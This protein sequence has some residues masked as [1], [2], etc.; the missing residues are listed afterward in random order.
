MRAVAESQRRSRR[1]AGGGAPSPRPVDILIIDDD[2]ALADDLAAALEGAGHRTA[3]ATDLAAAR[4]RCRKHAYAVVILDRLLPG[5]D[6]LGFIPWL[7]KHSQGTAVL[8]LS[9]LDETEARVHGLNAGADDYLGKPYAVEELLARVTALARR[10]ATAP[11]LLRAGPIALDRLARRVT[12]HDRPV[13]L[14]QREFSMLEC[15]MLHVNETVTRTMLVRD[16]WG[17]DLDAGTNVIDVHV[18]RLRSKL[19]ANGCKGLLVTEYG[20]GYRMRDSAA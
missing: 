20:V 15:L 1:A 17:Y 14:N 5:G 13:H 4:R 3:I 6:G 11:V 18:S 8:V 16:V 7:R 9:A 12:M 19:E 10:H 2:R